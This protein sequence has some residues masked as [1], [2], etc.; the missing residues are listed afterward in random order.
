[1]NL[2]VLLIGTTVFTENLGCKHDN[3]CPR[4]GCKRRR[5]G[6]FKVGQS[7]KR[8]RSVGCQ[9]VRCERIGNL[10]GPSED[11]LGVVFG[12]SNKLLCVVLEL[13]LKVVLFS[14]V[15]RKVGPN[16]RSSR[17][18]QENGVD[19]QFRSVDCL[20]LVV[21]QGLCWVFSFGLGLVTGSSL[22][23]PIESFAS[24][25]RLVQ[26]FV[27][28]RG[29]FSIHTCCFLLF[30]PHHSVCACLLWSCVPQE[31]QMVMMGCDD[32]LLG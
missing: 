25:G 4:V 31:L 9:G 20:G 21:R 29:L 8:P 32:R 26:F 11:V 7:D 17:H 1:M 13:L 27:E 23:R 10:H 19:E 6:D 30:V 15:Y 18:Y 12:S 16:R 14:P 22:G 28:G 5:G 24:L 3:F 2:S